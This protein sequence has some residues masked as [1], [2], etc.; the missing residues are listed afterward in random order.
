MFKKGT[1]WSKYLEGIQ[2]TQF[3]GYENLESE[4][5]KILK[6]FDVEGQRVLIFDKTP[7]YA[8]SGGQTGDK[9]KIILDSGET[10]EIEEVKKYE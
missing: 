6:D 7:F 1:D 9:G 10:V 8:E 3:I 5:S 4:N 2:P